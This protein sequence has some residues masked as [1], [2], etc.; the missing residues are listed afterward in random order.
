[1][2]AFDNAAKNSQLVALVSDGPLKHRKLGKKY[3]VAQ[4]YSYD[5][6]AECLNSGEID[7]IGNRRKNTFT[8]AIPS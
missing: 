8:L 4:H 3:N 7:L 5:R 6:Y 1:M 2:A